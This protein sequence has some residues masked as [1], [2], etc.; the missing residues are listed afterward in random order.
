MDT[1]WSR[2]DSGPLQEP[3][4]VPDRARIADAS[5]LRRD[6]KAHATAYRQSESAHNQAVE[7]VA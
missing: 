5:G 4:E 7:R 1:R 3:S 6:G 2:L